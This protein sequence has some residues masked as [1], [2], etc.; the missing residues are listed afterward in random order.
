MTDFDKGELFPFN[1]LT[2]L[3]GADV[4]IPAA[5]GGVGSTGVVLTDR[6]DEQRT[7]NIPNWPSDTHRVSVMFRD[8][9]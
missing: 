1:V 7:L 6:G 2:F 9:G 3:T 5:P 8:D 4:F